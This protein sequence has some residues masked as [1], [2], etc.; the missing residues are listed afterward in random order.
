MYF[1]LC[2]VQSSMAINAESSRRSRIVVGVNGIDGCGLSGKVCEA[3]SDGTG[4]GVKGRV[5][6]VI[7]AVSGSTCCRDSGAA[8]RASAS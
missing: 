5:R 2:L 6:K 7:V 4:L 1:Q 8:S 3:V